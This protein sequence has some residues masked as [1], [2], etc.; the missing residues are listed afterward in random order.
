MNINDNKIAIIGG[1][2]AG[3]YV[4]YQL[5]KKKINCILFEKDSRLGGRIYTY[6]D[7]YL[8]NVEAGAGRF[9][10]SHKRLVKLLKEL[11]L[12][13]KKYKIKYYSEYKPKISNSDKTKTFDKNNLIKYIIN[14]SKKE[15]I[16][17]LRNII[18]IDYVKKV[19]SKEDA[20]FLYDS[21][22]YTTELTIM[23]AYDCLKMIK[24][25]LMKKNFY[26]LLNGLSQIIDSIINIIKK[27]EYVTIKTGFSINSLKQYKNGYL[28]S[29]K[30]SS[31]FFEKCICAVPSPVLLSWNIIKPYNEIICSPLCRIYSVLNEDGKRID[32]RFT[33]NTNIRIYIPISKDVA[34]ISYTDDDY[35]KRWKKIY[36]N[37][38][39]KKLNYELKKELLKTV[40]TI[41]TPKHTRIFYWDC[42]VG[43][44]SIGANSKNFSKYIINPLNNLYICGENYSESNQQWIEGALETAE[45]VLNYFL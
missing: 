13:E 28:L 30:E 20:N 19:L 23:N 15:S 11:N 16:D 21:F 44:W 36:D 4:A 31:F 41:S 27:S 32:N 9:L 42:G 26:I 43:Y 18:F 34:M 45:H 1:G 25:H 35:A 22:G 17:T 33:T 5:S 2:I 37:G 39:Y 12:Y 3:L 38:G 40:K 29:N 8:G 7:K 14:E 10:L 6:N 24:N